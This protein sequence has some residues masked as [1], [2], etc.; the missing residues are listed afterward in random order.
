[1]FIRATGYPEPRGGAIEHGV[2]VSGLN[3]AGRR[4]LVFVPLSRIYAKDRSMP[5]M[6]MLEYFGTFD[7][8]KRK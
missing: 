3:S 2:A 6:E 1:M 7:G 4:L 8:K 5:D